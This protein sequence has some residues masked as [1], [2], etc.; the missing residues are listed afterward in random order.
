[1][2]VVNQMKTY[3]ENISSK[4]IVE[5]ILITL[6]MNYNPIIAVLENTKDLQN[7]ECW[8]IGVFEYSIWAKVE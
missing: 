8:R 5:K 3:E 6:M 7:L 1:M 2:K 4:R